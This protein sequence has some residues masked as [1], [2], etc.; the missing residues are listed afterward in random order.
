MNSVNIEWFTLLIT[1]FNILLWSGIIFGIYKY[2]KY[3]TETEKL[4]KN[5]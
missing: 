1:I 3:K 5:S 2:H 4:K